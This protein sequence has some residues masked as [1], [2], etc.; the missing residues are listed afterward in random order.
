MSRAFV[1]EGHARS[2]LRSYAWLI[3]AITVVTIIAAI[4]IVALRPSTYSSSSSVEVNSEPTTG[5]PLPPDMGT[6]Q[7][8]ALSESVASRAANQLGLTP[9]VAS[10]GL[11]VSVPLDTNILRISYSAGD[12]Q[13]AL[14]GEI[15]FTQAYKNFSNKTGADVARVISHPTL[16]TEPDATNYALVSGLRLIVG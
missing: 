7:Q 13:Q 2:L 9:E 15:A 8:I 4:T 12:P 16:P 6:E 11:S 1:G 14:R 10:R 3:V 5:T